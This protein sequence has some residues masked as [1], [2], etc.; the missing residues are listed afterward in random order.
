MNT[1]IVYDNDGVLRDESVSYEKSIR[2]TVAFF[3]SGKR[4]TDSELRES[5]INSNNDYE[6]YN[7]FQNQF[8]VMW[9]NSKKYEN[10]KELK[11]H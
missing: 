10:L 8:E 6:W 3:D 7:Y 1:V 4:A 5:R 11:T 2:D 9:R